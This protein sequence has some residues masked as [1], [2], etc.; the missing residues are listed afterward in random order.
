MTMA[1]SVRCMCILL[2]SPS[3]AL[4]APRAAARDVS[5]LRLHLVQLTH[6]VVLH[7]VDRCVEI[8]LFCDRAQVAPRE[9]EVNLRSENTA[10]LVVLRRLAYLEVSVHARVT[11]IN[12]TFDC[13][14]L[15]LDVRADRVGEAHVGRLQ[16]V[17]HSNSLGS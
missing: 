8:F 16:R 9:V 1:M 11:R 12:D 13:R 17:T 6:D 3:A 5:A 2:P 10:V 4:G 14:E 15:P 7:R